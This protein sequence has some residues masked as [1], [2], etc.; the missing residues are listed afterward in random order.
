M[1]SQGACGESGET[2]LARKPSEP[3]IQGVEMAVLR[4]KV[5]LSHTRGRGFHSKR[6]KTPF[7]E[8][9]DVQFEVIFEIIHPM[10]ARYSAAKSK[11]CL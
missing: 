11:I 9:P 6:W 7:V 10:S 4:L 2:F 8:V 1:A 5:G 3:H